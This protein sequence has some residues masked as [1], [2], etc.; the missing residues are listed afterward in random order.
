MQNQNIYTNN[1]YL[2][3]IIKSHNIINVSDTIDLPFS[4]SNN[5]FYQQI[6]NDIYV[7]IRSFTNSYYIIKNINNK[8]IADN[9][10]QTLSNYISQ[11]NLGYY[12]ELQTNLT[13][14]LINDVFSWCN[15]TSNIVHFNHIYNT[16]YNTNKEFVLFDV[17]DIIINFHTSNNIIIILSIL[18]ILHSFPIIIFDKNE[19]ILL[20]IF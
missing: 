2:F 14:K 5:T 8:Y 12:S 9:N 7:F 4:I 1:Y 15:N 11:L 18:H 19:I 20:Q 10:I 6:Y 3:E 13:M 16:I 17:I